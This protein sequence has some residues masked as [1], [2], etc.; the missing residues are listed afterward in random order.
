MRPSIHYGKRAELAIP[1]Q[2]L[3]SSHTMSLQLRLPPPH[4]WGIYHHYG[5]A[6]EKRFHCNEKISN[7][8]LYYSSAAN[9]WTCDLTSGHDIH[10][11]E[12]E[13]SFSDD[14]TSCEENESAGMNIK[15]NHCF[16]ETVNEDDNIT[17]SGLTMILKWMRISWCIYTVYPWLCIPVCGSLSQYSLTARKKPT[18]YIHVLCL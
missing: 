12:Q 16:T 10:R 17:T 9:S 7:Y 15:I 6:M 5:K 4:G 11:V 18:V 13:F 2:R 8:Q 14:E 3:R 1:T